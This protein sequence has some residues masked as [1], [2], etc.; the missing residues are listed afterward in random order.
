MSS[1]VVFR[2]SGL[3]EAK[4]ALNSLPAELRKRIVRQALRAASKPLVT[5]ARAVAPV[6]TAESAKRNRRRVPGTIKRNIKV[7]NS[8][9]A[10][11]R[12]GVLGVYVTVKASRRDLKRSPVTG[13]PYYWRWLEG[14]HRIVPRS[15]KVGTRFGKARY[16]Q[17]LRARRETAGSAVRPY[18]FL[19]PAYRA[20]GQRV[21]DIFETQ[22][23]TRVAAYWRA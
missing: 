10:N 23:R 20:M 21:I 7:F 19:L 15:S 18:P 14:G 11:G 2:V 17:S 12:N 1:E 8:K 4:R 5:Y 6:L 9:R 16:A 22:V 13:D 3:E